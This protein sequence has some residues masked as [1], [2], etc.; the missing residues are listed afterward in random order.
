MGLSKNL[1]ALYQK[2]YHFRFVS[3]FNFPGYLETLG[4]DFRL[5]FST[6][7]GCSP[8]F[9]K[10]TRGWP[11][12]QGSQARRPW[13]SP[14]LACWAA[15][16]DRGGDVLTR[17]TE[18]GVPFLGDRP[19]AQD[20]EG[21]RRSIKEAGW[22]TSADRT[23]FIGRTGDAVRAAAI[24]GTAAIGQR[25]GKGVARNNHALL[26]RSRF[27]CLTRPSPAGKKRNGVP[28]RVKGEVMENSISIDKAPYDVY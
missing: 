16:F 15:P 24:D 23:Q 11:R 8:F 5:V 20:G 13:A 28:V 9:T 4:G 6:K 14:A 12:Y 27:G 18:V 1:P 25:R 19:G 26:K 10:I 21:G 7:K 2:L 22:D 3:A 17:R